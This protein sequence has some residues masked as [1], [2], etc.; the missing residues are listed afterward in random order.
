MKTIIACILLC[1]SFRSYGVFPGSDILQLL[2]IIDQNIKRYEQ[3]QEVIR[4]T[5][6]RDFYEKR[7][8]EGIN[9]AVNVLMTLPLEEGNVLVHLKDF[10][11]LA[12]ELENLYGVAVSES[13]DSKMFKLHDESVA[14]SLRL[15]SGLKDYVKN[16]EENARQVFLQSKNSSPK[17]AQRMT[18]VTNSQILH[19]LS[20][21]IKIN[22][23]ML[24]LQSEQFGVRNKESKE[25]VGHFYKVNRE[26]RRGFKG[27]RAQEKLPRF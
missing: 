7:I 11:S 27:Y 22:G 8:N 19:A 10:K 9:N 6:D 15:I 1:L 2:R 12:K 26:L 17:G 20:Q 13:P 3:L 24:K 16:Q 5:R 21:L 18:A 23:Q 25:S 4:Q 14:E